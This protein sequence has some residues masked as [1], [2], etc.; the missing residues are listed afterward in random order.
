[1][2]GKSRDKESDRESSD[3]KKHRSKSN[4]SNSIEI[5]IRMAKVDVYAVSELKV[6][7]FVLVNITSLP[8]WYSAK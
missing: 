6:D 4:S 3:S 8:V 5:P 2:V 1:M 7:R